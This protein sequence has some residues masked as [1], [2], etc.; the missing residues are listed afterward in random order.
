MFHSS[1]PKLDIIT[2]YILN[3]EAAGRTS[4]RSQMMFGCPPFAFWDRKIHFSK[5]DQKVGRVYRGTVIKAVSSNDFQDEFFF[6]EYQLL[7]DLKA[8]AT[9]E[10][11]RELV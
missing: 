8:K 9:F 7:N 1:F 10:L 5:A 3:Y 2:D 11:G 4:V 6:N